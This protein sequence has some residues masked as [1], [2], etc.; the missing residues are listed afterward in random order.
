MVAEV[1]GVAQVAVVA[2]GGELPLA[3]PIVRNQPAEYWSDTYGF[4]P[5]DDWNQTSSGE[6]AAELEAIWIYCTVRE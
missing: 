1:D 6:P 2:L 3:A 5:G 4:T